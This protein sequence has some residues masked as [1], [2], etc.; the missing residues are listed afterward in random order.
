MRSSMLVNMHVLEVEVDDQQTRRERLKGDPLGLACGLASY[1]SYVIDSAPERPRWLPALITG[2]ARRWALPSAHSPPGRWSNTA[3]LPRVLIY[4][5]MA[6]VLALCTTLM[7]LSPE[8]TDRSRGA[9]E[10]LRPHLH[11]PAGSGGLLLAAGAA[12]VAKWSLGGF[13][14]AFSASVASDLLGDNQYTLVAGVRRACRHH[15]P[16]QCEPTTQV[17][18]H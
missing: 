3:R 2:S 10:S 18:G 5:I 1:G 15:R 6:T 13:W 7:A 4:A 14:Q 16:Q 17:M 9:L 12:F 8:T 11:V